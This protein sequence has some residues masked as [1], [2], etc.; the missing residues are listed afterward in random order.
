MKK[1]I[2]RTAL[3]KI[4]AALL[5]VLV[6]AG[7]CSLNLFVSAA[8]PNIYYGFTGDTGSVTAWGCS[9]AKQQVENVSP[10]GTAYGY[11][12][13]DNTGAFT[14]SVYYDNNSD[15][16]KLTKEQMKSMKAFVYWVSIPA[17]ISGITLGLNLRG[18]QGPSH[19]RRAAMYN[20]TTGEFTEA[21]DVESFGYNGGFEGWVIFELEGSTFSTDWGATYPDSWSDLVDSRYSDGSNGFGSLTFYNNRDTKGNR[22]LVDSIGVTDSYTGFIDYQKSRPLKTA[23]V[24]ASKISGTVKENTEITLTTATEGAEIYYTLDSTDPT[25]SE[26]RIKYSASSPIKITGITTIRAVA[27]KDGRYSTVQSYNYNLLDPNIPNTTVINDGSDIKLISLPNKDYGEF[28]AVDGFG[29]NGSAYSFTNKNNSKAYIMSMNFNDNIKS[30]DKSLLGIQECF[31]YWVSTMDGKEQAFTMYLNSEGTGFVGTVCTYN[32]ITGELKEYNN[33]DQVKVTDFEGY[34]IF[35]LQD[36]TMST[37][38]G[39]KQMTWQEYSKSRDIRSQ[40]R[41]IAPASAGRTILFDEFALSTSYDDFIAELKARPLRTAPPTASEPSGALVEATQVYLTS[42]TEGVDIYYTL[43]G[44]DPITSKTAILYKELFMAEGKYDSPIE[45]PRAWNNSG[46]QPDKDGNYTLKAVAVKEEDGKKSYSAVNTF[47][48]FPEPEYDGEDTVIINNGDGTGKNKTGW[49]DQTMVTASSGVEYTRGDSGEKDMG[50]EYKIIKSDKAHLIWAS[51]DTSVVK[52]SDGYNHFHNIQAIS[53]R[54]QVSGIS[55][56]DY[57]PNG[58]T[59]GKEG[60]G[61]ENATSYVVGDDGKVVKNGAGKIGEGSYTVIYIIN[62]N[63]TVGGWAVKSQ[64]FRE[65]FKA[66][67]LSG[68]GFYVSPFEY[69]DNSYPTVIYDDF[70]VHFDSEK[71][72]EQLGIDGLLKDYDSGTYENASMLVCNDGSGIKV[73]GGLNKIGDGLSLRSSSRSKDEYCV[74]VS[75]GSKNADLSFG[76]Y[77]IDNDAILCDGVVFWVENPKETGDITLELGIA[78]TADGATEYFEYATIKYHY[79]IDTDG[80]VSRVNGKIALAAGF[81]GWVIIPADNFHYIESGSKFVNGAIDFDKL[82]EFTVS[83]PGSDKLDGKL[84][85]LDDFS[86]YQ[87]LEA[88][89]KSHAKVWKT[90]VS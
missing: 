74:E 81:R 54:V 32:T 83:L 45:L 68:L 50:L 51:F 84:I 20:T 43:D 86:I 33:V 8:Q 66:N 63:T 28:K 16:K 52:G 80:G 11:T 4:T 40:L 6:F 67:K 14:V 37:G 78:D 73:N 49:T 85:Y 35:K 77:C 79:Q 44:S 70:A 89:V 41:Y 76:S 62:D 82:T 59:L 1:I 12:P 61:F 7:T 26:T 65:Y 71:L 17:D 42:A 22:I 2:S 64:S 48:Y 30:L 46:I 53:Y 88:V 34:I 29:P 10:D 27:V 9:I 19:C 60:C 31:S 3:N 57:F 69:E 58:L 90:T 25:V 18:E 39:A 87:S 24:Q 55:A 23:A 56:K 21:Y 72:F 38:W 75:L 36:C 5:S 15:F 13:T 47:V